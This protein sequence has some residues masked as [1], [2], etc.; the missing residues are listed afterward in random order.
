MQYPIAQLPGALALVGFQTA[1]TAEA[2]HPTNLYRYPI[3]CIVSKLTAGIWVNFG[4][5]RSPWGKTDMKGLRLILCSLIFTFTFLAT[6][7]F[8]QDVSYN[9]DMT[10][11]F[12]KYKTYHWEKHPN[13]ADIDPLTISQLSAALDTELAKKGLTRMEQGTTDLAIVYQLAVKSEKE[14]T[15]F[16]SGYG[17][18]AGWGGSWY[19]GSGTTTTSVN[20]ITVGTLALDIYDASTKKLIWRGV[21]TKTLDTGAKPE[22]RQKNMAKGAAKLLK[23]Y[24]PMVKK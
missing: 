22:K 1:P 15:T 3:R 11:D 14:L 5:N 4:T 8:A 24:P 2:A 20:N 23:Q 21:A 13:S 19:G 10:A 6:S 7:A 9:F 12:S 17:M 16:S 18:G